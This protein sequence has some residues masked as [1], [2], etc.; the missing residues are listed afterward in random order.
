MGDVIM[1]DKKFWMMLCLVLYC[2]ML[3]GLSTL[4]WYAC[5]KIVRGLTAVRL[6]PAAEWIA[7]RTGLR[8]RVLEVLGLSC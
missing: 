8:A 1:Y 7:R 4:Y 5:I 3:D 6:V 2:R